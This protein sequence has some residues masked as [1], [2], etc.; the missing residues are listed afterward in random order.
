MLPSISSRDL[1]LEDNQIAYGTVVA[2]HQGGSG[3]MA[4][5]EEFGYSISFVKR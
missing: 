3:N 2:A 5:A 4:I 1:D